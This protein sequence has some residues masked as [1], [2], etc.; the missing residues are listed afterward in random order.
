MPLSLTE[1]GEGFSS[2]VH[3]RQRG[4]KEPHFNRGHEVAMPTDD[5]TS[6]TIHHRVASS[7]TRSLHQLTVLPSLQHQ[8]LHG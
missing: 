5:N 7:R 8:S 6:A 4:P 3:C 2:T 1:V